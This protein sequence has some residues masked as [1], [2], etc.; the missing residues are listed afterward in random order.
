MIDS[1]IHIENGDYTLDWIS[2]FVEVAIEKNI[3]E[4]WLLEHCYRFREFVPM[5]DSVRNYSEYIS[6]WFDKKAGVLDFKDYLS[7]VN[8][9][10]QEDWKVKI[11]FGLEIC[12]FKD[13]EDFVYTNTQNKGLDFLVGSIHF[14]DDFS[15]DHKAEHWDNIDVDYM[16]NRFFQSSIDLA[17][18]GIYD[19]IAHPDSIKLFGHK[20][21]FSL[22]GYYDKLSISLAKNNMYVE[23]NSG[24]FRRCPDTSELGMNK[25]LIRTLKDNKVKIQTASDAHYPKDV[26][27]TVHKM[28][29]ILE[30]I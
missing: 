21:S 18:S 24:C 25:D 22:Q 10:R 16:Y 1:H 8:K 26:G 23:E 17:N 12:Y 14:I 4:I 19:G 20:P 30:K 28:N 29:E 15:F 3:D 5:Y 13:F 2:E 7:L 6:N 11:K 9:V 27:L